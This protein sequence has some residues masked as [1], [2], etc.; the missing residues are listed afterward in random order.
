MP[1]IQ[2]A[3]LAPMAMALAFPGRRSQP[4]PVH[5]EISPSAFTSHGVPVGSTASLTPPPILWDLHV[6]ALASHRCR[7]ESPAVPTLL[8]ERTQTD[9]SPPM[10]MVWALPPV[11]D[12]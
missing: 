3:P 11:S 12:Q 1:R 7:P 4:S 2:T 8:N 6:L 9:P 5:L 10:L